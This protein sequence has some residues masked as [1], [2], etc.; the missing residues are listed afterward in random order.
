MCLSGEIMMM[1]VTL[2]ESK[3]MAEVTGGSILLLTDLQILHFS[4]ESRVTL[5]PPQSLIVCQAITTN[6]NTNLVIK[7]PIINNIACHEKCLRNVNRSGGQ[8]LQVYKHECQFWLNCLWKAG[9]QIIQI[10]I[11]NFEIFCKSEI[12]QCSESKYFL[13]V[14]I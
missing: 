8:N 4:R 12:L 2:S 5:P 14:R 7:T 6:L 11:F 13:S 10:L 3:R 9:C 1:I